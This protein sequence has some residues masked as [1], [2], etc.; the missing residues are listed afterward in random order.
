MRR[1]HMPHKYLQDHD[2]HDWIL[3]KTVFD[4]IDAST[5]CTLLLELEEESVA[6]I[7]NGQKPLDLILR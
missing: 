3:D 1:N 2:I 4:S 7:K 6:M 5:G